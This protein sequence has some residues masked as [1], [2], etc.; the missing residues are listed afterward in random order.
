MGQAS[1]TQ[2]PWR[3]RI[4]WEC[5]GFMYY[6]DVCEAE[7]LDVARAFWLTGADYV[8]LYVRGEN[9]PVTWRYKP[10]SGALRGAQ[11]GGYSER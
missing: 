6:A 3:T 11:M 9:E 5:R 1:F 8:T 2:Y 10:A 4:G 7:C